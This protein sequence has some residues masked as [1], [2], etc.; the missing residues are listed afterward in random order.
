M[1]RL[2]V[3]LRP[4]AER[5]VVPGEFALDAMF[6]NAGSEPASLNLHQA[7]HPALVL[8][9]RDDKGEQVAIAPPSAPD[10]QDLGP[11]QEIGPGESVTIR[12]A[13]F[14]DTYLPSGNYS[15]RYFS[16]FP[17]LGG[18][19]DDPLQSDDVTFAVRQPQRI[20][21]GLSA[22]PS[23][24]LQLQFIVL[25]WWERFWH[26]FLCRIIRRPA[27]NSVYK[28]EVDEAR[29][30]TIS[31]APPGSEAWNGNYGWQA[32]FHVRVDE[33]ACR[34]TATV[35]LRLVGTI[36][37]AQQT[38]WETAIQNAWSNIFKLCCRC[39]CCSAGYTIV[40]DI[41]FVTS[42]EHHVVNVG[43]STTN[44][45]NWG[46]ADTVDISHEVGHMLGALDEYFTVNGVVWG[47]GR[48]PTGAIMNNPANPPVDR[49]YD[50][51][52]AHA[53]ALLGSNC[54]TKAVGQP[55]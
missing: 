25:V 31:D 47:P 33:A 8:E 1:P 15:V 13:G 54:T 50:L 49:H 40:I 46:A 17:E 16:Q 52:R 38:A 53:A 6:S 27:C 23:P 11:P 24:P 2:Q 26:W 44:M 20:G 4:S 43:T 32:R 18:S 10:E 39:C 51:V 36:T 55:C 35:R 12:Y 28:R 5:E 48:Q 37:A 19:R 30:E 21:G 42:G 34:V 7:S 3:T 14:L 22:P 41:Q 45:T 29:A 9:V